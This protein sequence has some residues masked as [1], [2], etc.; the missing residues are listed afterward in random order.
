M[1][2][3]RCSPEALCL[4]AESIRQISASVVLFAQCVAKLLKAS[5]IL[6]GLAIGQEALIPRMCTEYLASMLDGA[7]VLFG[8]RG[9]FGRIGDEP[10]GIFAVSA[11][12]PPVFLD[13]DLG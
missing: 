10:V 1:G 6:I 4:F 8:A 5:L 13:T 7:P 9:D 3:S 12:A 11:A 2:R